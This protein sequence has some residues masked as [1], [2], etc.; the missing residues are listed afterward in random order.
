MWIQERTFFIPSTLKLILPITWNFTPVPWSDLFPEVS[1]AILQPLWPC[2]NSCFSYGAIARDKKTIRAVR[3]ALPG[4]TLPVSIST[5]Q[6]L[7][8]LKLIIRPEIS[9]GNTFCCKDHDRMVKYSPC[10]A[11]IYKRGLTLSETKLFNSL[12]QPW[13]CTCAQ[14]CPPD[15]MFTRPNQTQKGGYRRLYDILHL[16]SRDYLLGNLY[17]SAQTSS[18]FSYGATT[19]AQNLYGAVATAVPGSTL[20]VSS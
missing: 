14:I 19:R 17:D 3:I 13:Y 5:S 7:R 4:S 18:S 15:D 8:E 12:Q 11:S 10:N 6:K 9:D 1:V 2:S 20:P 16:Q